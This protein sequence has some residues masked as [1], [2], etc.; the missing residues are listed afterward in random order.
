[1]LLVL[2]R[3][4]PER[5]PQLR[6]QL[7]HL[8]LIVYGVFR[9]MTEFIRETPRYSFGLSPYQLLA[10]LLSAFAAWRFFKRAR[11][12]PACMNSM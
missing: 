9:L 10:L 4:L 12:V 7:F 5:F 3:G 11:A 1:V 6:G 2:H 8:Y